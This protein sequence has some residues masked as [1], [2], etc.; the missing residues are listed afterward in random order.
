MT[1]PVKLSMVEKAELVDRTVDFICKMKDR[2][3]ETTGVLHMTMLPRFAREC[4]RDMTDEV[5]WLLDW[6]R[7]DV[8][9]EIT[10]R[11]TDRGVGVEHSWVVVKK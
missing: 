6:I 5:L 4:T 10:D 11:P 3:G 9:K 7:R 1:T 2:V 8:N